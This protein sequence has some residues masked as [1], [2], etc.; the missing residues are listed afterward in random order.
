MF[1]CGDHG[2]CRGWQPQ[3]CAV[4]Y[5]SFVYLCGLQYSLSYHFHQGRT[6]ECS[7]VNST[8]FSAGLYTPRHFFGRFWSEE[9]QLSVELGGDAGDGSM[10]ERW[11]NWRR[12]RRWKH[13]GA[14]VKLEETHF[15]KTR[16]QFVT[17]DRLITTFSL[18]KLKREACWSAG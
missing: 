3:C 7:T 16:Q 4:L 18:T 13:A 6:T 10:L 11:L 2:D 12:R 1:R 17:K 15:N 9:K 14:L 5:Y 8:N